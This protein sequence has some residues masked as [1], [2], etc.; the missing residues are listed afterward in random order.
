MRLGFSLALKLEMG[1]ELSMMWLAFLKNSLINKKRVCRGGTK[2]NLGFIN[3]KWV[4]S[5]SPKYNSGLINKKWAHS[6]KC[7]SEWSHWNTRL[8]NENF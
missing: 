7:N 3:K 2:C 1:P 4:C 8:E 6:Y 5:G